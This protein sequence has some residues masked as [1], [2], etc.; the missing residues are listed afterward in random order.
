MSDKI[1]IDR[2]GAIVTITLNQPQK[3]N[4]MVWVCFR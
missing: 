4:A 1:L 2:D 3:R